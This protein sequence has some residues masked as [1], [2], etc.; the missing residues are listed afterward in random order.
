VRSPVSRRLGRALVRHGRVERDLFSRLCGLAASLWQSAPTVTIGASIGIS[1]A[2]WLAL[3]RWVDAVLMR[4]TD[5]FCRFR[6]PTLILISALLP[7]TS[8]AP[9]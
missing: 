6:L 9:T 1:S 7:S 3:R 5:L 2:H 4:V 8:S